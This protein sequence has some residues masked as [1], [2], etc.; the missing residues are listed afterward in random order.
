[1]IGGS[2]SEGTGVE[3]F[4]VPQ[5]ISLKSKKVNI[6]AALSKND[7]DSFSEIDL[8]SDKKNLQSKI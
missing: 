4:Q 5:L 2:D 3:D 8:R 1:M 7:V 6:R